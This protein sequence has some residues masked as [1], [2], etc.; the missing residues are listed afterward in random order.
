MQGPERKS[1]ML[2]ALSSCNLLL[3]VLLSSPASSSEKEAWMLSLMFWYTRGW[4][5]AF[6]RSC[7]LPSRIVSCA[8]SLFSRSREDAALV[9]PL[10]RKLTEP[11]LWYV[12]GNLSCLLSVELFAVAL[13]MQRRLCGACAHGLG[14]CI[15]S[16]AGLVV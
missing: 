5:T 2:I 4:Y 12:L 9:K 11:W 16:D 6:S 8:E 3:L 15:V 14:N 10:P 7:P 1:R 13:W